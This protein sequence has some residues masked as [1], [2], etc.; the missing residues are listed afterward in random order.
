MRKHIGKFGLIGTVLAFTAISGSTVLA[1][2]PQ[3]TGYTQGSSGNTT[4]T[5]SYGSSTA[6]SYQPAPATD[7]PNPHQP[8]PASYTPPNSQ[9]Y[10]LAAARLK[11]CQNR[12]KAITNIM[13]RIADRGQKQVALFSTIAART[14]TFYDTRG[15]ILST[16]NAL[17][18]DVHTKQ[19]I[20]QTTVDTIKSSSTG[21]NCEGSD[22]KGFVDSFQGSLKSEISALQAY[23]TSV[24]NLIVGVKSAQSPTPPNPTR[25]SNG[26]N[27]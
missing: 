23:R 6:A 21:F 4:S 12:E 22:P 1:Q 5:N 15:N 18:A 13:A 19:A 8:A 10:H 16:Y 11:A 3:A 2:T 17:V 7:T 20:A 14:E 24:K 9:G 25:A 27:Q 26:S